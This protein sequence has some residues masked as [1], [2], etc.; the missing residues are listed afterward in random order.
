M[1]AVDRDAQALEPLRAIAQVT[2]ADL[3]ARP[4]PLGESRFGA[5]IVTNYLWRPLLP[6]IVEAV[7][8]GGVL[9]Y[10]TFAQGNGAIGK[11]SN[12]DFLL[13]PGELLDTVRPHL[14]VIAYEDG[15]LDKPKPA[16]VQRV[17]AV[18][19]RPASSATEP[20]PAKYNLGF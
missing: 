2:V 3:E 15:Y 14:R 10:E 8:D 19:E 13:C 5:V 6:R 17:C 7:A 11:P 9:I 4:W 1:H 18:R 16:F 20:H 12:P